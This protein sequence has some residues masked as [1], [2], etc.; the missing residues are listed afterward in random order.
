M[1]ITL[2]PLKFE[3]KWTN[4][5]KY[6]LVI[7]MFA[8]FCACNTLTVKDGLIG[9]WQYQSIQKHQQTAIPVGDD[10]VLSLNSNGTFEYHLALANK[11]KIGEWQLKD[12]TLQLTYHQPDTVRLFELDILTKDHLKFHEGDVVF[13]LIKAY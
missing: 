2:K 9:R 4:A 1:K 13:D 8:S 5:N 6:L 7:L 10:D 12:N 3:M 11:H